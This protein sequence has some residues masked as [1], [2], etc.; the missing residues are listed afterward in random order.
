MVEGH[1]RPGSLWPVSATTYPVR[2]S[3]AFRIDD[4][5]DRSIVCA[6]HVPMRRIINR[7]IHRCCGQGEEVG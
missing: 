2:N 3:C 6:V 5:K 1:R 7:K 4:L